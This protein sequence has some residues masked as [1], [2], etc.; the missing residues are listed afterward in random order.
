MR[1]RDGGQARVSKILNGLASLTD[2]TFRDRLR[3][4][5]TRDAIKE[6]PREML[7]ELPPERHIAVLKAL[8]DS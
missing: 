1:G 6:I 3:R 8:E 7:G 4:K 5:T 2:Q